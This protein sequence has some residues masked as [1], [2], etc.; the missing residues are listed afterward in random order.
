MSGLIFPEL[1]AV[2][3]A[4]AALALVLA[5]LLGGARLLRAGRFGTPPRTACML[6]VRETLALDSRRR[7]H[8]VACGER[9]VLLLTGG[10]QDVVIGW[11]PDTKD[12]P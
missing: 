4:V 10:S 8:V 7:I 11:L 5:L 3:T 9:E 1:G 2:L 12:A 6:A